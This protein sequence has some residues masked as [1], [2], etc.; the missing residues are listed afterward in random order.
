MPNTWHDVAAFLRM[1][2]LLVARQIAHKVPLPLGMKSTENHPVTGIPVK[3]QL[4]SHGGR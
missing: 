1:D 4:F 3:V 2:L